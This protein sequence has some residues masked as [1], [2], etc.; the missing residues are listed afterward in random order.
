MTLIARRNSMHERSAT[1]FSSP[2][3]RRA[4]HFHE[5]L[6]TS[7]YTAGKI[8]VAE[9]RVDCIDDD[10]RGFG[11]SAGGNGADGEELKKFTDCVAAW[12]RESVVLSP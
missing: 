6:C 1:L 10:K 9:T 7:F 2:C 12:I 5:C 8:C 11:S 4:H 3:H